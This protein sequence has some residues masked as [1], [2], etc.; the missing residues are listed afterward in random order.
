V[1]R[2]RAGRPNGALVLVDIERDCVLEPAA[3]RLVAVAMERGQLTARGSHRVM[4][5]A[6]T[7]ADLAGR[8]EITV[9]EV[10]E[11]LAYRGRFDGAADA[12][13]QQTP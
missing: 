1:Q 12:T 6:R 10:S 8:A 11:A 5:V 9:A 4:R 13:A 2:R 3:Q 7:I